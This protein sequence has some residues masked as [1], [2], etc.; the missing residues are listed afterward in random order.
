MGRTGTLVTIL[1][2]RMLHVFKVPEIVY[3]LRKK[4]HK[5]LVVESKVIIY[6]LKIHLNNV[7]GAI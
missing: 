2:S 6:L 3:E 1:A 7:L 5:T 4:R